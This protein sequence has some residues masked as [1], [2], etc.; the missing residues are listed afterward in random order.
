MAL[1]SVIAR[2]QRTGQ[3]GFAN[4]ADRR[5]IGARLGRFRE[6]VGACIVQGV[7]NPRHEKWALDLL[8]HGITPHEA[9]IS[10]TLKDRFRLYRQVL[11]LASSGET[12]CYTGRKIPKLA[13]SAKGPNFIVG[14]SGLPSTEP[15]AALAEFSDGA[16]QTDIR[17]ESRLQGALEAAHLAGLRVRGQA[18]SANLKLYNGSGALEFDL[19]VDASETP[20]EDLRELLDLAHE[21]RENR[22]GHSL[23]RPSFGKSH[24]A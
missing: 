9:L 12:D 1:L 6:G 21:D 14:G 15:V 20:I 17:L 16:R 18:Q 22:L 23:T 13:D 8:A 3:I 11:L 2:C 5:A 4:F 10:S 7:I 19:R 24:A